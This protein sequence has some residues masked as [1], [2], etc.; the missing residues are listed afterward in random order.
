[1]RPPTFV[2]IVKP[3]FDFSILCAASPIRQGYLRGFA[4][5]G[6]P[7]YLLRA[8]DV[9]RVLPTLHQPFVL[10]SSYDYPAMTDAGRAT[11]RAYPH[12]VWVDLDIDGLQEI[13]DPYGITRPR[14]DERIAGY[15]LE[16]EPRFVW[17][18]VP[19][20]ELGRDTFW[21]QAGLR[22]VSLSLASDPERY[23]PEPANLKYCA[24]KMA[25][26]GGYWPAKAIQFDKYL[27]PYEDTLTV[28]GYNAWP[29]RGYRGALPID[30]ERV[31][32]HNAGVCPVISM[33]DIVLGY[34]NERI[35][36]VLGS[37]GLAV[38]DVA[39]AY[40]ELF[41]EDELLMPKNKGEYHAMIQRALTDDEFGRGYRERGHQA[42]LTRHTYAH[43]ARTVLDYLG[44]DV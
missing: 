24:T 28:F 32:Y 25:Y 13:Y 42:I 8:P 36:K 12:C 20:S 10:L 19:P 33:P 37:G 21:R 14:P 15:V 1:M 4:Q 30:D 43:R 44:I 35:F 16:S 6:I 23:Y 38:T 22:L 5:I 3:G 40:R 17:A 11:L 18:P 39:P 41:A 2:T 26:V 34:I 29:Y 7:G 27:R 31:L 9:E